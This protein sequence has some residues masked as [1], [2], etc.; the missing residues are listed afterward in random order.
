MG[1]EPEKSAG[2]ISLVPRLKGLRFQA[3]LP[4][5]SSMHFCT[6]FATSEHA[7]VGGL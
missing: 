7:S 4:A 5:I 2:Y 6:S 1:I 3:T